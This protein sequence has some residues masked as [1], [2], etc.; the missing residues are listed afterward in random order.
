VLRL[1]RNRPPYGYEVVI[2]F[3]PDGPGVI[4]DVSAATLG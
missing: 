4:V 3:F 1:D 2:R